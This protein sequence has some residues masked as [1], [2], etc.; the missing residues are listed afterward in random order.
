[1]EYG[2]P[3][4]VSTV[5]AESE[6]WKAGAWMEE[7]M[8]RVTTCPLFGLPF[9]ASYPDRFCD[10]SREK[11]G[12]GTDTAPEPALR[13][14]PQRNAP[15]LRLRSVAAVPRAPD[16]EWET[17]D[18]FRQWAKLSTSPPADRLRGVGWRRP[19]IAGVGCGPKRGEAAFRLVRGWE[20]GEPRSAA[21]R[22]RA[23]AA[24]R[25][26]AFSRRGRVLRG[27][28]LQQTGRCFLGVGGWFLSG[29]AHT[30]S[31]AQGRCLA[32]PVCAANALV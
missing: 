15:A 27:P 13:Y 16:S 26:P 11:R 32:A 19:L 3:C 4:L 28:S 25:S 2:A 17:A 8:S 24:H 5:G 7:G 18:G 21:R 31:G 30:V 6:T 20:C 12:I 23:N 14:P 9:S 29:E 22:A 1:M 10:Q